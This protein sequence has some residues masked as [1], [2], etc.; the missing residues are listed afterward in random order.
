MKIALNTD[1]MLIVED[2]PLLV[3]AVLG[4]FFFASSAGAISA[5]MATQWIAA[6]FLSVAGLCMAFCLRLFVR[7]VQVIFD[8]GANTIT[9]RSRSFRGYQQIKHALDDFSHA[10]EEGYDTARCVLIFDKGMSAGRHP[11]TEYSTSGMAPRQ[12]T[13]AINE[14]LK[15]TAPVDS[16]RPKA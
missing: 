13:D 3:S 5:W 4:F 10:E 15:R 7:R 1:Q 14:W 12:I 6:L 9:F 2:R 11:V 8:R 16:G